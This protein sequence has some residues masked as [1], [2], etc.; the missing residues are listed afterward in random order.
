[1]SQTTATQ[2]T[3]VQGTTSSAQ[4]DFFID[5]LS[6]VL[7]ENFEGFATDA[8]KEI[9]ALLLGENSSDNVSAQLDQI[10]SQLTSIQA[11]ITA[12]PVATQYQ[13][14]CTYLENE[15]TGIGTQLANLKSAA[16]GELIEQDITNLINF[17]TPGS[18]ATSFTD[19][20]SCINNLLNIA[21][22]VNMYNISNAHGS[23]IR[24]GVTEDCQAYQLNGTLLA[25]NTEAAQYVSTH[26]KF[27]TTVTTMITGIAN[28]ANQVYQYLNNP[29]T[30]AAIY[31]QFPDFKNTLPPVLANKAMLADIS[32]ITA[33]TFIPTLAA[34]SL[35]NAP[36]YLCG[37]LFMLVT[38]LNYNIQNPGSPVSYYISIVGNDNSHLGKGAA[39][40]GS[41]SSVTTSNPSNNQWQVQPL[42]KTPVLS[43]ADA[44]ICV[45]NPAD[46]QYMTI[47]QTGA[48]SWDSSAVQVGNVPTYEGVTQWKLITGANAA[49]QVVVYFLSLANNSP[50]SGSALALDASNGYFEPYSNGSVAQQ[51]FIFFTTV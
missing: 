3:T 9:M 15:S 33:S 44:L 17:I 38:T 7:T 36:L 6:D 25:A 32:D 39:T 49:G 31:Q 18:G 19:Y 41:L 46:K 1:M 40:S 37:G 22:G 47:S 27:A 4:S 35:V 13:S 16:S 20:S 30:Q 29:A 14:S 5:I 2:N 42:T 12:L 26:T 48:W 24:M 8:A 51:W 21:Y 50:Y 28:Q 10:S 34:A 43:L 45:G 23:A 11:S